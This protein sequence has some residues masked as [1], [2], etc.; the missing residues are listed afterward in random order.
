M[1]GVLL[2]DAAAPSS[3]FIEHLEGVGLKETGRPHDAQEC[4]GELMICARLN[5]HVLLEVRLA[6]VFISF[7]RTHNFSF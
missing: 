7:P 2:L 6:H 1:R 3:I 4:R 5:Y